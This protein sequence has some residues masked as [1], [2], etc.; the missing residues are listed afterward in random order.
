MGYPSVQQGLAHLQASH[1]SKSSSG[2]LLFPT[3][4]LLI[5]RPFPLLRCTWCYS[6]RCFSSCTAMSSPK[7]L[8]T[9]AKFG[10]RLATASRTRCSLGKTKAASQSHNVQGSPWTT[11]GWGAASRDSAAGPGMEMHKGI[12]CTALTATQLWLSSHPGEQES[13]IHNSL[14]HIYL[15]ISSKNPRKKNN[16]NGWFKFF[17]RLIA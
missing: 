16:L 13:V 8:R 10:W 5:H 9:F 6:S 1:S 17:A 3:E 4:T 11:G 12:I 14:S 2:L 7:Y 15:L